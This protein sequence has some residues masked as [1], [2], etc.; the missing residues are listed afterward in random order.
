MK[1]TLVANIFGIG[2]VLFTTPLVASLKKEIEGVQIDYL[3]NARAKPAIECNP[4]VDNIIV[5]EK[6]DYVELLKHSKIK[7]LKAI[8]SLLSTVRKG[9]YDVVFDFTLSLE[10]SFFFALAGIRRRIGLN[11]KNRG[12]FLTDKVEFTGFRNK[13]VTEHYLDLLKRVG[14]EASIKEM[15]LV[16]DEALG[17]WTRDYLNEHG[18]YEEPLAIV[19]PGGGASW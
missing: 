17:R 5:Y 12:I 7:C 8:L 16:P 18:V 9:K 13:H 19:V 1:R 11:Y 3:C 6:D 15:Q 2:D 10:F 14:I 4:N